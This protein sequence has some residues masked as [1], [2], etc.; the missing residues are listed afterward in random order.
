MSLPNTHLILLEEKIS[1]FLPIQYQSWKQLV[2]FDAPAICQHTE[3]ELK[4]PIL[5]EKP[6]LVK[7]GM[8]PQGLQTTHVTGTS[9]DLL[10]LFQSLLWPKNMH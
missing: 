3:K 5:M 4:S 10:L 6:N 1:H 9:W 2:A 7:H 8:L